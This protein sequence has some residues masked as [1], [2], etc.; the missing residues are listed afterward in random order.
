[1]TICHLTHMSR[2]VL[3]FV[4]V[5]SATAPFGIVG[6]SG[7][8]AT[9]GS[10]GGLQDEGGLDA[11]S[12]LDASPTE[13]G[14][15]VATATDGAPSNEASN[16]QDAGDAADADAS[17]ASFVT[18]PHHAWPVL[19][20]LGGPVLTSP[21]LVAIIPQNHPYATQLTA[22]AAAVPQSAWWGAVSAT[23]GL[24]TMTSTAVQAPAWT[25]GF[26]D[27]NLEQYVQGLIDAG[28]APQPSGHELYLLFV[29][30]AV[31][32]QCN[33]Q[34]GYHD[35][36][37]KGGSSPGD[38]LAVSEYCTPDSQDPSQLDEV[39]HGASHE[40]AE[41][42]T[43]PQYGSN[44]AWVAEQPSSQPWTQSPWW[45][46]PAG[47]IGD[48]CNYEMETEGGFAYE[49]V[50]SV[51]AAAAGGDPC[52]PATSRT[53]YDVSNVS[54]PDWNTVQPGQTLD[55]SLT[56]WS[57]GPS[58]SW[59]QIGTYV[60]NASGG[61]K[62]APVSIGS[63]PTPDRVGWFGSCPHQPIADNAGST[64]SPM[65]KF[66]APAGAQSGDWAVVEIDSFRQDDS[67]QCAAKSG[68]DMR[69]FWFI[70]FYVP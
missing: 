18:A 15:D 11:E 36:W 6:C 12:G 25:G 8:A 69:H 23:Y 66:T 40:I 55:V 33:G 9:G 50:W 53:F 27:A 32:G 54:S 29:P 14:P 44:P 67:T 70:G 16:P 34:Y 38:V 57:T 60:T 39:T 26:T 1:M 59:W 30:P 37:P 17:D 42:C 58:P 31:T 47:E 56:G 63:G 51:Q 48:M 45:S 35:T 43:N 13:A 19:R 2:L 41:G 28:S 5:L 21:D 46:V 65:L 64:G 3:G 20:S 10:D 22:F 52:I 4:A 68:S 62:G 49:R 24:G 7:A 61:M